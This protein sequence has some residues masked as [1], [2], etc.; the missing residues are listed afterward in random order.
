MQ[1][2]RADA[3]QADSIPN[4][5]RAPHLG[6]PAQRRTIPSPDGV[7]KVGRSAVSRRGPHRA[8]SAPSSGGLTVPR[9][10]PRGD[11][12]ASTST[13][14]PGDK[15]VAANNVACPLPPVARTAAEPSLGSAPAARLPE[16][17]V[18]QRVGTG[19]APFRSAVLGGALLA[20]VLGGGV[21]AWA[22]SADGEPGQVVVNQVD[23]SSANQ[24]GSDPAVSG[25]PGP[26]GPSAGGAGVPKSAQ[27][28]RTAAVT[29]SEPDPAP[30]AAAVVT[31]PA[32]PSPANL[33]PATVSAIPPGDPGFGWPSTA[34]GL[35][36]E[37]GN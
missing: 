25:S 8:D 9:G 21:A 28:A 33:G 22:M 15:K 6:L 18:L 23:S 14:W 7:S 17:R 34:F 10:F 27:D 37:P 26:A 29:P 32:A 5:R 16:G 2:H 11:P 13:R 4:T 1:A 19:R 30:P 12:D 36:A 35:P 3:Q 24:S 20:A 31:D